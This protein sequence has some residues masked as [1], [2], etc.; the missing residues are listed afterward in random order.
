MSASIIV[1]ASIKDWLPGAA[2]LAEGAA[3]QPAIIALNQSLWI[4][5]F[6][7]TL[8]LLSMAA[9]GGAVLVLNLRLLGVVLADSTAQQVERATRPWL[10]GGLVGTVAT[11]TIMTLATTVSTL[12]STAFAV[13]MLALV[14]AI[15]L[16]LVVSSHAR[17]PAQSYA[18]RAWAKALA[19]LAA[20]LWLA[21]LVLF[22]GTRNLGAG[23]LLVAS[24]GFLLIATTLPGQ[25][26]VYLGG[27]VA[28]LALG[29]GGTFFLPASE[30]GD[31]LVIRMSFATV[32][33]AALWAALHGW[34]HLRH[35]AQGRFSAVQLV[36]LSSILSWVTVAAAGRWI[37]FS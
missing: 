33:V 14:A 11:G 9:L 28:I 1:N 37:G 27:A 36:A 2:Q 22:A 31:A 24:V 26:R 3:Q 15:A 10:L 13:K 34:Q 8:H 18:P 35:H 32:A 4:F 30:Q 6:I 21:S 17:E 7:E 29:L 5:S 20:I 25:R 12:P 23:S 16:S 19:G